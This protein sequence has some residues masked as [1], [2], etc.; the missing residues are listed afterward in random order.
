[1]PAEGSKPKR[2]TSVVTIAMP[3]HPTS[4][5]M[6]RDPNR[7]KVRRTPVVRV[8]DDGI[9]CDIERALAVHAEQATPAE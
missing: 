5:V 2:R 8:G 6:R 9:L 7:P 4:A 3:S 1:M